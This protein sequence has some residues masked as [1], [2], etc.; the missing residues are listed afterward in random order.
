MAALVCLQNTDTRRLML[1]TRNTLTD[2]P[3]RPANIDI[4]PQKLKPMVN[5]IRNED[6]IEANMRGRSEINPAR[7]LTQRKSLMRYTILGSI[8][9][10]RNT[11]AIRIYAELR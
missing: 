7:I 3:V 5:V 4:M 8:H 2:K 1:N 11:D 6:T 9:R 10:P